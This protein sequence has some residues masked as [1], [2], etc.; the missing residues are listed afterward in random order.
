MSLD[1]LIHA[2]RRAVH[3][4]DDEINR[5]RASQATNVEILARIQEFIGDH[6]EQRALLVEVERVLEQLKVVSTF[7]RELR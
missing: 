2:V 5:L 6:T 7:F 3:D 1:V 4:V